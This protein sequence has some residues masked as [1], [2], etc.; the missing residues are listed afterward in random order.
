MVFIGISPVYIV[1]TESNSRCTMTS[2][3]I[4]H[5]REAISRATSMAAVVYW[6]NLNSKH[7]LS[8][9][10]ILLWVRQVGVN[11]NPLVRLL[12]TLDSCEGQQST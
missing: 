6:T 9:P 7:D 2:I 10:S 3:N 12:A 5:R 8:A 1:R 11:K 4:V